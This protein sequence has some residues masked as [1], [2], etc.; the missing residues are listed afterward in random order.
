M[1]SAT[2]NS[3]ANYQQTSGAAGSGWSG[4]SNNQHQTQHTYTTQQALEDSDME[5]S[6]ATNTSCLDGEFDLEPNPEIPAGAGV[7]E[8][9]HHLFWA[10]NKAKKNW[11]KFAGRPQRRVRRKIRRIAFSKGGQKGKGKWRSGTGKG[12]HFKYL[13]AV[14][15]VDNAVATYK[16]SKGARKGQGKPFKRTNPNGP[17]GKPLLCFDCESD[18]HLA[19]HPTCPERGKNKGKNNGSKGFGKSYWWDTPT[20]DTALRSEPYWTWTV[21]GTP[22]RNPMS[23]WGPASFTGPET[24]TQVMYPLAYA[25][26]PSSS[27]RPTPWAP[28]WPTDSEWRVPSWSQPY[29]SD[30]HQSWR[31]DTDDEVS[32]LR[33]ELTSAQ[34]EIGQAVMTQRQLDEYQFQLEASALR[35]QQQLDEAIQGAHTRH[36]EA[37]AMAADEAQTAAD[38]HAAVHAAGQQL[39][40]DVEQAH[41]ELRRERSTTHQEAAE[42]Q[43]QLLLQNTPRPQNL[44]DRERS[45]KLCFRSEKR[46]ENMLPG[47]LQQ[48]SCVAT[49]SGNIPSR[50]PRCV[51]RTRKGSGNVRILAKIPRTERGNTEEH[52]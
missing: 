25:S 36:S 14:A 12:H 7:V 16:A 6:T 17:D 43:R 27:S 41:D 13:S 40:M 9:A 30:T 42:Y 33:Q 21:G 29:T 39:E 2:L 23:E 37:M 18:A 4:S 32:V 3:W 48:L 38:M 51:K 50:P 15:S 8:V 45:R 49:R 5:S 19:G 1:D 20:F 34:L 24:N 22:A 28:P 26:Q 11:R 10:Y 44:S 47:G 52:L 31:M 46:D 35:Q